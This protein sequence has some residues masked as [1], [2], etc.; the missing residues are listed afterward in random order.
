M[1]WAARAKIK[2]IIAFKFPSMISVE[3][4]IFRIITTV[5]IKLRLSRI[6]VERRTVLEPISSCLGRINSSPDSHR[7]RKLSYVGKAFHEL[8]VSGG[9]KNA[10][11]NITILFDTC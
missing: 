4:N 1:K 2:R 5:S 3:K 10:I 11:V 8:S 7:N 6:L 9:F